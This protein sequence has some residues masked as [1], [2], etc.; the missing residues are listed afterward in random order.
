MGREKLKKGEAL[1]RNLPTSALEAEAQ[2]SWIIW[3]NLP[4]LIKLGKASWVIAPTLPASNLE[5]L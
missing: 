5:V 1:G 2:A 4:S 3:P